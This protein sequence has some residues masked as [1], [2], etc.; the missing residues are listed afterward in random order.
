MSI[1]ITLP[2]DMADRVTAFDAGEIHDH[3]VKNGLVQGAGADFEGVSISSSGLVWIYDV[4]I[5]REAV[6]KSALAG[7]SRASESVEILS[8]SEAVEFDDGWGSEGE[9]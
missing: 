3:L 1:R 4:P 6:I 7:Y 5:E 9:E 8:E 2:V